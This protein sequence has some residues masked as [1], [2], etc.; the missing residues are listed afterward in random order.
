MSVIR[1]GL[2]DDRE[3]SSAHGMRLMTLEDRAKDMRESISLLRRV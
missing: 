2:S 1:D 3:A